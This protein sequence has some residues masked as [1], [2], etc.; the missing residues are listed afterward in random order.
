MWKRGN[1]FVSLSAG[2]CYVRIDGPPGGCPLLLIHGATVP[3]WEFERV[4]PYLTEAGFRTVCP[5]LYGHG[6]SDRPACN[7]DAALFTR[8]LED[9]LCALAFDQRVHLLGHSLGSVIAAQLVVRNPRYFGD[10]AMVAPLLDFTSQRAAIRVLELPLVGEA[11]MH[12]YAL[13]ML[14]RR[15]RRRYRDIEN[16]RFPAMFEAQLRVPGFGRALLSLVRSGMLGDQSDG[17]RLLDAA[18]ARVCVVR[19]SHDGIFTHSQ[20]E[21]LR[22]FL[23]SAQYVEIDNT[24]H[25]VLLTHPERVAPVLT[26]FFRRSKTDAASSPRSFAHLRAEPLRGLDDRSVA[27]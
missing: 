4:V 20:C 25:S 26:S 5:D 12:L 24:P 23:P 13:P 8:Q 2:R 1:H 15:R 17:Y 14:V 10:I 9:L 3:G 19:G 6:E 7:Y 18:A 22:E 16:G 27:A 11:L 21:T